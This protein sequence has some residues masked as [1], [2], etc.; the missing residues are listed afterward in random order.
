MAWSGSPQGIEAVRVACGA[1]FLIVTPGVRPE[2][3]ALADQRRVRTPAEALRADADILV[4]GRPITGAL[5]P[6]EAA[7]AIAAEVG[8][9]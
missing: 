5:D 2:G 8:N 7:R 4:I 6:A 1:N 9:P 3:A